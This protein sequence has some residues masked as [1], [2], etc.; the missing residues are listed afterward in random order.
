MN[1]LAGEGVKGV[2]SFRISVKTGLVGFLL[3]GLAGLVQAVDI[4]DRL[5]D[6]GNKPA[7]AGQRGD[8]RN[9]WDLQAFDGKIYIGMGSTVA[10]SGP[11]PV[12][13][14]D[15]AAG[16]WDDA[17]ETQVNQEAIELYRV[18][19]GRLYIPAADPKGAPPKPASS[20]AAVSTASGRTFS[21]R[22]H[23]IWRTFVILRWRTICWSAS[24][25]AEAT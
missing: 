8:S 20:I 13:A 15:H 21:V 17:P 4:T 14:F 9:V 10:D 12:W 23:F 24:A 5:V 3:L 1:G 2:F 22:A 11:V 19:D 7:E 16:A 25:T 18:I 6:L